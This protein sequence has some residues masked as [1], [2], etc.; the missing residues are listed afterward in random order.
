MHALAV[1]FFGF[2][3]F[4]AVLYTIFLLPET[5]GVPIEE[6]ANFVRAHWFWRKVAYKGG[7]IPKNNVAETTD[8]PE[9]RK[10]AQDLEVRR[11]SV[12]RSS[13]GP[14][15]SLQSNDGSTVV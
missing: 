7:V 8:N 4:M 11:D 1:L 3:Q 9:I 5:R 2:W 6:A 12:R 15:R 10:A 13:V 14:Q